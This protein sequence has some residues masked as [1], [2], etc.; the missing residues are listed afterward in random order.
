MQKVP[1]LKGQ[2][3]DFLTGLPNEPGIYQFLDNKKNVIY[4]GKARN[5]RNRVRSYFQSSQDK[6]PK[7]LALIDEII[8]LDLTITIMS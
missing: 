4:V 5:I 7:T 1:K 6:N 8:F 3:S 2:I